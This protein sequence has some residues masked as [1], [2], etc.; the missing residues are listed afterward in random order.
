[1]KDVLGV[2]FP[3]VAERLPGLLAHGSHNRCGARVE[4][5]DPRIVF[6]NQLACQIGIGSVTDD[7]EKLVSQLVAEFLEWLSVTSDADHACAAGSQL[8]GDG[9]AETPAGAGNEC[10]AVS[11]IGRCHRC[12][13]W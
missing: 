9:S 2:D 3:V 12:S 8:G 5:K 1:M 11:E 4:D 13:S 7:R 10:S 6:L